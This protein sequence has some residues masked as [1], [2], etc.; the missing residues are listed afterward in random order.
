MSYINIE[1]NDIYFME[2]VD[3]AVVINNDY[4][5]LLIFDRN[6]K[7]SY[8]MNFSEELIIYNSFKNKKQLLL[9]CPD[10]NCIVHVDLIS[11]TIRKILLNDFEDYIF[12]PL[13]MWEQSKV[14]L[15][16]HNRP[17]LN[18]DLKKGTVESI[19]SYDKIDK[20]LKE[21]Y[22]KIKNY[23]I[24]KMYGDEK[25]AIAVEGNSTVKLIDYRQNIKELKEFP[26]EQYFDFEWKNEYMVKIGDSKIQLIY[27]NHS[28]IF[29]AEKDYDFLR[30]KIMCDHNKC[31]LFILSVLKSD[32]KK[33][34][35]DRIELNYI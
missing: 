10:N 5:G 2:I 20:E 32:V 23:Q 14:I 17:L 34:R 8:K 24:L 11:R 6:L 7:Q 13:Y 15:S 25:K 3:E 4:H 18:V 31:F 9:F 28:E 35:I 22:E 21:E 1:N 33:C 19:N 16:D 29:N 30:G 12:S 26:K 27:G